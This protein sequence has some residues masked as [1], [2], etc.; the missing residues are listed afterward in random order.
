MKLITFLLA[1][2]VLASPALALT[3]IELPQQITFAV[4]DTSEWD[5]DYTLTL[6]P[7][8]ETWDYFSPTIRATIFNNGVQFDGAYQANGFLSVTD[9]WAAWD[10]VIE[11]SQW[12]LRG[13]VSGFGVLEGLQV[14]AVPAPQAAGI[15][16][17][18]GVWA[19]NNRQRRIPGG[20]GDPAR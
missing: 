5:G 3:P 7:D 1:A 14:S 15:L 16:L 6:S 20:V 10:G 19:T 4:T 8:A 11:A 17:I 12:K 2:I 18:A 9:G 13:E